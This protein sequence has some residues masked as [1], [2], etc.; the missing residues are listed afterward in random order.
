MAD[1]GRDLALRLWHGVGMRRVM[2]FSVDKLREATASDQ[3][4]VDRPIRSLLVDRSSHDGQIDLSALS[5]HDERCAAPPLKT[6]M[7]S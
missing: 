4:H 5:S 2:R 1:G 6:T 3:G 7:I